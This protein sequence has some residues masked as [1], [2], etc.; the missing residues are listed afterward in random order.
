MIV[1]AAAD[2]AYQIADTVV[3]VVVL[4][5]DVVSPPD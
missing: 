1:G 4:A 3:E 5:F 2:A